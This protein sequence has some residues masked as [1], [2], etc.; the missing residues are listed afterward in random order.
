M[1]RSFGDK[2][3]VQA[4]IVGNPEIFEMTIGAEDKFVILGSDGLFEYLSN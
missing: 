2:I 1:T 4:G 3:G